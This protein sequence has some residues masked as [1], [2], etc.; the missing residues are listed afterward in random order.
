MAKGTVG[1]GRLRHAQLQQAGTPHKDTARHAARWPG[2]T[3]RR[4]P[5]KLPCVDGR[6][7]PRVRAL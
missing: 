7:R 4:A 1:A 2:C 6:K 3:R 5:C